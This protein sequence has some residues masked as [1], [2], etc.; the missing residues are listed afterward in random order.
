MSST[1]NNG[2]VRSTRIGTRLTIWGTG[3]T[4][5]VCLLVCLV[6]Y[7]S[8]SVALRRE[9][10][11]FLQGE[12]DEL[13][14]MVSERGGDLPDIERD[15]RHEL[16]LRSPHDVS[17]RMLDA[18][19]R[20][21]I[22]SDEVDPLPD[23]WIEA[24]TVLTT[25]RRTFHTIEPAS[26]NHEV[27][28]YSIPLQIPKL[29]PCVAQV[30]YKMD[31]VGASLAAFRR[32][33]VAA[34]AIGAILAAIGGRILAHRSLR[35][36]GVMTDS[37][38]QIGASRLTKRLDRNGNGDELDRLAS[39]LN[40]ML[41]RIEQQF[42]Q[43]QQFAADASHELRTPLA[44]LRGNAEVALTQPRSAEHL[45][46]VLENS[47]GHYD[48]LTRIAG[49]LL[50]LAR[51]DAGESILK[52][53]QIVLNEAIEA[54]V[55]LYEP[56]ASDRGLTLAFEST[57]AVTMYADGAR[58][59]QLVGNLIDNAVKYTDGPG[60]IT[61]GL[62]SA[63]GQAVITV[64]DTGI[65]IS[66]GDLAHVFDRFFRADKARDGRGQVGTGL[67]LAIC[68]S[69]T[70]AHGGKIEIDSRVGRGT[71]VRVSLPLR[72]TEPVATKHTS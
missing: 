14:A 30:A 36:V 29:Q 24:R 18:D 38:R 72:A 17:F 9:I 68:R 55:D 16:Q 28:L 1:I 62:T 67:G 5:L 10:D 63:G 61:I 57:E 65:G 12:G 21:L 15:I 13:V 56:V 69:V 41:D 60:N 34:L 31:R 25:G 71:T 52:C 23:P 46:A 3:I 26:L 58:L 70:E 49:D 27:R 19:G 54:V 44:A 43:M 6:L 11:V 51:A 35:P 40:D 45:R 64:A 37:A 7:A 48:R 53:E 66:D 47:I 59:R 22:A 20:A 42:R 39:T 4:L 33:S 2:R 8:M 50:L 32:L